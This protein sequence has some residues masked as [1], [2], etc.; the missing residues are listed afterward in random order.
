MNVV[1]RLVIDL[2]VVDPFGLAQ[3]DVTRRK[4]NTTNQMESCVQWLSLKL[5]LGRKSHV[6]RILG[7]YLI[8]HAL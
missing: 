5:N 4:R 6:A 3:V 8:E 2:V 7:I 1:E